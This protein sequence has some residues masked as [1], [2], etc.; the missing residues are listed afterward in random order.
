ML[1]RAHLIHAL[2]Q[3]TQKSLKEKLGFIRPRCLFLVLFSSLQEADQKHLASFFFVR[4]CSEFCCTWPYIKVFNKYEKG[5]SLSCVRLIATPRTL[6]HQAPL[7]ME[8]SRQEYWSGLP[9]LSSGNLPDQGSNLVLL[10]CRQILY[11]L[12][13]QGS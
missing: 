3:V 8:L 2:Q 9:F 7:P 1:L 4:K 10:H 6:A 12:S 11:H 5:Q 13:N